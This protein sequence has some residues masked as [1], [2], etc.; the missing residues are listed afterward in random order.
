MNFYTLYLL[1]YLDKKRLSY[2]HEFEEVT[3]PS[4]NNVPTP[5][6][7]RSTHILLRYTLDYILIQPDKRTRRQKFQEPK[8]RVFDVLP[9]HVVHPFSLWLLNWISNTF[10]EHF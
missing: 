3:K 10:L 2:E 6:T 7:D 4:L 9:I 8:A 5:A 1:L